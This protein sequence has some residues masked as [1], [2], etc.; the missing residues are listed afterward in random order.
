[1]DWRLRR[2]RLW[3]LALSNVPPPKN[4]LKIELE[5]FSRSRAGS[6]DRLP[7]P[8]D[9]TGG[10][11]EKSAL[12]DRAF[13]FASVGFAPRPNFASQLPSLR[14][15][16]QYFALGANR[17]W[18][19]TFALAN[20]EVGSGNAVSEAVYAAPRRSVRPGRKKVFYSAK[21]VLRKGT[22]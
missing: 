3:F 16:V 7:P 19:A 12:F 4:N 20:Q 9:R 18:K 5:E 10:L 21:R 14:R 11:S 15:S 1:V 13:A 22:C 2:W 8:S 17:P 6:R